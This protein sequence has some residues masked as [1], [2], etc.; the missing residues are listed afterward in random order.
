[1]ERNPLDSAV[2]E[3]PDAPSDGRRPGRRSPLASDQE[4]EDL[5]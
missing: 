4:E 5:I 3:T 2:K 1:M